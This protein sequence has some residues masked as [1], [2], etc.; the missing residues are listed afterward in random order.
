M[1][2]NRWDLEAAVNRLLQF[3]AERDWEQFHLPKELVAAI[4]IEAAELQEIFLWKR[5]ASS[6][7]IRKESDQLEKVREELADVVIFS[8]LLAHDLDI[9]LAKAIDDKITSN[10][11]RYPV[12]DHKGVAMKSDVR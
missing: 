1:Q 8:L 11:R 10:Q 9:D 5:P 7:E 2:S 3:R 12:A 4:S 6:T